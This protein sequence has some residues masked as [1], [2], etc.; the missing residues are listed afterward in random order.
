MRGPRTASGRGSRR[1]R[2]RRV[3]LPERGGARDS[4][5]GRG[6]QVS[7]SC[8]TWA[9]PSPGPDHVAPGPT[10]RHLRLGLLHQRPGRRARRRAGPRRPPP[11]SGSSP[12]T[13][14]PTVG[15]AAARV[16]PP[17]EVAAAEPRRMLPVGGAAARRPA[18]HRAPVGAVERAVVAAEASGMPLFAA[19]R[20]MPLPDPSGVAGRRAA[21]P[22]AGITTGAYLLA[23]RAAG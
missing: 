17:F 3:G 16:V 8:S 10:A 22:A 1:G 19:W 11:P 13:R 7:P 23:V 6:R 15:T 18:R 5:A 12:R 9:T 20:A 4:G 2:G 14:S 21:A